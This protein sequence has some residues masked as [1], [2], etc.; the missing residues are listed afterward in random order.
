MTPGPRGPE[1]G[2]E[3]GEEDGERWAG[4]SGKESVL[5]AEEADGRKE[6]W[7]QKKKKK[8]TKSGT[9]QS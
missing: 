2:R 8:N 7:S 5:V 1:E 4:R 3:E 6:N 9:T